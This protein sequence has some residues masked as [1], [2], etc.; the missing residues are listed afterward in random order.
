MSEFSTGAMYDAY[1]ALERE[2]DYR[3]MVG[4]RDNYDRAGDLDRIRRSAEAEYRQLSAA[5][6]RLTA[7]GREAD[8][9]YDRYVTRQ[10]DCCS[11]HLSAP[12]SFCTNQTG[13]DQ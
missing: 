7:L 13:D 2:A 11:C 1:N 3:R 10:P 5:L 12:C 9:A 6:P 8:R 4:G